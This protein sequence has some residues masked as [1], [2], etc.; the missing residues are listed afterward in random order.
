M[1]TIKD[2]A[3]L[4]QVSHGTVSNVINGTKTV[5]SEIVLRV[6]QAIKELG[7]LP[8]AKAQSL[9]KSSNNLIGIILPNITDGI[10]SS[11]Y[12]GIASVLQEHNHPIQLHLSNDF[13]ESEKSAVLALQQQRASGI[14]IV[15]C[16]AD[17]ESFPNPSGPD[18]T[19]VLYMRR[20]PQFTTQK[21]Y[22]GLN[23]PALLKSALNTLMQK[24]YRSFFLIAGRKDFSNELEAVETFTQFISDHRSQGISGRS[25][26]CSFGESDAFRTCASEFA[27]SQLPDV[28]LTTNEQIRNAAVKAWDLFGDPLLRKPVIYC[29]QAFCFNN[30]SAAN[31][32]IL[33]FHTYYDMGV[34]AAMEMISQLDHGKYTSSPQQILD[35]AKKR[36]HCYRPQAKDS[37]P[38]RLCLLEGRAADAMR[39]LTSHYGS[40]TQ[41]KIEIEVCPYEEL[42]SRM[43]MLE[44]TRDFDLLQVNR[45][46]LNSCADAGFLLPLDQYIPMSKLDY[47]PDILNIY[48]LSNEKHWGVPYMMGAQLLFYRKDIFSDLRYQRLYYEKNQMELRPPR[49]WQEFDRVAAFFTRSIN[50][51]SPVEYGFSFGATNTNNVYSFIPRLWELQGHVFDDQGKLTLDSL[52]SVFAIRQLRDAIDY[53][54]PA[55][56]HSDWDAQA[57]AFFDGHV[58]MVV[59]YDSHLFDNDQYLNSRISGKFDVAPL[60][61]AAS[62]CGGWLLS[63][64][65][66]TKQKE[67]ALDFLRWFTST[68]NILTYNQLG[69]S[70]PGNVMFDSPDMRSGFSWVKLARQTLISS[71]PML[72]DKATIHQATFERLAGK[73]LERCLLEGQDPEESIKKLCQQIR[74]I[75][76]RPQ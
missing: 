7:Y 13:V 66:K 36:G 38:L 3:R 60:P 20:N 74:M 53:C 1:A 55:T 35:V 59:I 46:W 15:S 2:V 64:S 68:D 9:R 25:Q 39:T 11:L 23:E 75:S 24:G 41:K 28:I 45:P 12:A 19:N 69:G 27:N 49:S 4:A 31:S 21:S 30:L 76:T 34:Q 73:Q 18:D 6:Q 22:V 29:F 58:S 56:L 70:N 63:I 54:Y 26:F 62:I 47:S 40:L 61:G 10:Y 8:N 17:T 50:P 37:R 51:D 32:G 43:T 57:Q 44:L 48:T 67:D 16:M 14:M 5:N 52:K 72:P 71:R 42:N 65:S 33:Q